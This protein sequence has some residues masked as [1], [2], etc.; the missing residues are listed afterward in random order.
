M[1]SDA[2]DFSRLSAAQ[3]VA[4]AAQLWDSVEPD[5]GAPEESLAQDLRRRRDELR[6]QPGIAVDGAKVLDQIAARKR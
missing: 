5:A 2:F 4:L 6:G 3:R 1:S